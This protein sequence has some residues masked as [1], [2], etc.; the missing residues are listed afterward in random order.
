MQG[1]QPKYVTCGIC[2]DNSLISVKCNANNY[3]CNKNHAVTNRIWE[4]F[5]LCSLLLFSLFTRKIL[6]VVQLL[7]GNSGKMTCQRIENG[8]V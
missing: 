4:L 7:G 2:Y 6:V 1:G 3:Y 5:I 8:V